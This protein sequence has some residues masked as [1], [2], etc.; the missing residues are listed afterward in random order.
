MSHD[1]AALSR[2]WFEEVWNRRNIGIIREMATDPLLIHGLSED[3]QRRDSREDFRKFH[4]MFVGAF[5]DLKVNVEDVLVDGDRSAVRLSF[6]GTHHGAHLGIAPTGRPFK[7]T[8]IVII[9][10]ENG[11]LAEG[12]NE[13]DADGMMK[14]LTTTA[15]MQLRV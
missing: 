5:P 10:W 9:R 15:P 2:R 1:L 8:A 13:F 14:Q 12:W 4:A 6:T 7:A 11:K 3:R